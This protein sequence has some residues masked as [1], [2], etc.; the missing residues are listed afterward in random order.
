MAGVTERWAKVAYGALFVVA[1]PALLVAWARGSEGVVALPAYG[2]ATAGWG[3]AAA[4]A[5]LMAGGMWQLW[6]QGGGLPM[7]AFPPERLVTAGLYR[8]VAHPI[9]TGFV[10]AVWGVSMAAASRSGLWMV[11]PM[12]ALGC[13][14]LVLGYEGVELKRRF[15]ERAG[16]VGAL[17][18]DTEEQAGWA[19]RVRAMWLVTL[20]WVAL[21]WAAGDGPRWLW[22][23]ALA[24]LGLRRARTLRRFT[25]RGWLAMA[26]GVPLLWPSPWWVLL[27][28]LPYWRGWEVARRGAELVANS[29]KEWRVGPV[30][31]INHGLWVGLG[32]AV[33]L[34]LVTAATG[35]RLAWAVLGTTLA[36]VAGAGL[37]AQWVEGSPRLQRPFGFYGGLLGVAA[38]CALLDEVWLLWGAYSLAGPWVQAL[39]RLRCLVQGC[40]HGAPARAGVGIVYRR[41]ESRVSRM[42]H[43]RGVPVHATQLY[44]ILWNAV[45]ALALG[46][47]WAGGAALSVVAGAWLML[48]GVGRFVEEAFRGEVQTAVGGGLRLYQWLAIASVAAGA[49]VTCVGGTPAAPALRWEDANG[50]VAA[51]GFAATSFAMGVDFPASGRR[52]A[53][54]TQE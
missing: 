29:W 5:L 23:L 26:V 35:P 15:G 10:A 6:Q 48:N 9:Y 39:G 28:L 3:I 13:V 14:A 34:C 46:R 45:T 37:W 31:L 12:A 1:L 19:E 50:W 11:T 27:G 42:A 20:P 32:T 25:V 53:R 36:G 2:N 22:L 24:P 49:A 38:A 43:L 7:N 41:E 44:S 17:A 8:W 16:A 52:F 4:G 33:G 54:L 30:R 40:C 51:A 18:A 21:S 47:L